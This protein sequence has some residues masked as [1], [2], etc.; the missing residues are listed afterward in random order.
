MK[1]TRFE[2]PDAV[3]HLVFKVKP[4]LVEKFIELDHEIWTKELEKCPALVSK[5]VWV[6]KDGELHSIICWSSYEE[7][8]A[9][10]HDALSETQKRFDDAFGAE[11]YEFVAAYH[12]V[13]QCYKITE[14]K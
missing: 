12:D 3:E 2:N 13:N 6:A 7:W 14:Y 9:I 5:E 4:E 10:D 8:K 1:L 11:N